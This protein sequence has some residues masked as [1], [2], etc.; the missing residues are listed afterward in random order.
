MT[1]AIPSNVNLFQIKL[2]LSIAETR[3]FSRTAAVMHMEQSTLSRRIAVLEQELGFPLFKRDTRPVQLTAEGQMLREP[4]SALLEAYE[5]CLSQVY[6]QRERNQAALT[7][8]IIDSGNQLSSI[9]ALGQAAQEIMHGVVVSF[10]VASVDQFI[11]RLVY[12]QA[13]LVIT[14]EPIAKQLD[15]RF[16]VEKIMTVPMLACVLTANPLSQKDAITWDDLRSQRFISISDPAMTHQRELVRAQALRHGFEPRFG[17]ESQKYLIEK[18]ARNGAEIYTK[19]DF[20]KVLKRIES[21]YPQFVKTVKERGDE[22]IEET[23]RIRK[24]NGNMRY[25]KI[26]CPN[27]GCGLYA[28]GSEVGGLQMIRCVGCNFQEYFRVKRHAG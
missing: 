24:K 3:N 13:D 20:Y 10:Q 11:S 27:C 14:S 16:A 7:V 15:C 21:A 12:A 9:P 4:W 25:A 8:C 5:Q 19:L 28:S 22:I 2:F 17:S 26:R 6:A 23:R 18:F 1:P